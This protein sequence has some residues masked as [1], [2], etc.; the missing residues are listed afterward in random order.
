MEAGEK[1]L[2]WNV[3]PKNGVEVF[4]SRDIYEKYSLSPTLSEL[5]ILSNKHKEEN[6]EA[7]INSV[8][9]AKT[10]NT[11]AAAPAEEEVKPTADDNPFPE[12]RI[13]Y[14]YVSSLTEKE[15]KTYLYLMTKFSKNPASYQFIATYQREYS[16]YLQ[17]KEFLNSEIAEFLKFAQ[18]A[19]KS[20]VQDYDTISEDALLYTE[21]FLRACI[22]HVKKYPEFYILHEITSI[23][24]GKFSTELT[25][26]LEKK[27]LALGKARFLKILSPAM[28]TQLQLSVDYKTVASVATPEQR[29]SAMHD[30]ISLDPNAEKLALKYC[31][32]VVLNSQSLF[33]LLNNHG[34]NYKEQWEIPVSVKMIPVAGAKPVK[35]IYID[36]PLPKKEITVREKNQIFHEIPLDT[37]TSKNS[38]IPVSAVL[39]DNPFEEKMFQWDMPPDAC[40][41]R[42]TQTLDHRDL[43]FDNDVTELETFGA[44]CKPLKTSRTE[45]P[46]ANDCSQVNLRCSLKTSQN[47]QLLRMAILYIN[48]SVWMTC[49]YSYVAVYKK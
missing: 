6:V 17:M 40:Q 28:H 34:L 4:F 36:S 13:P 30:D 46:P 32:Q 38:I 16:Q 49:C 1:R 7:S 15:Q 3:S 35:V 29:A 20:C 10:F 47:T 33:T 42:R 8:E 23:M 9:D 41:L 48:Y 11:Q 5:W 25:L 27:L 18:N 24:G 44:T 43:D 2:T 22:G 37:L 14:P 31:P 26:K 39:M 21:Q 12:P 45:N 19:A